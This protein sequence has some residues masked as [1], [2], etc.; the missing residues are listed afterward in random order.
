MNFY[1]LPCQ[2]SYIRYFWW[3]TWYLG[4]LPR[5]RALVSAKSFH[6]CFLSSGPSGRHSCYGIHQL[7]SR[8]Y[9]MLRKIVVYNSSLVTLSVIS[10]FAFHSWLL[11]TR[12]FLYPSIH[13][14]PFQLDVALRSWDPRQYC[15]PSW[16]L[17]MAMERS[18]HLHLVCLGPLTRQHADSKVRK[19]PYA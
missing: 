16:A 2:V 17:S 19:T 5:S 6:G 11:H 13:F 1:L 14:N 10:T 18:L 15:S 12:F 8:F 3:A 7:I 4:M 9:K